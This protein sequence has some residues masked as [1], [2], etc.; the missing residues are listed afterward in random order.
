M[1]IT[2]IHTAAESALNQ[3]NTAY[4]LIAAALVLLMTPGLAFFYGGMVRTKSV[5][6]MM[7]MSF[8][9]I[10]L[11]S[12]LWLFYGFSMAFGSDPDIEKV[13]DQ[14]SVQ[15]FAPSNQT[16][17]VYYATPSGMATSQLVTLAGSGD[18][19]DVSLWDTA[20]FSEGSNDLRG[21][22]GIL[23]RGRWL[24][25]WLAQSTTSEQFGIELVRVSA[26]E[27]AAE[28]AIR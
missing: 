4:I 26:F 25:V 3:G 16:L 7:M 11:I 22:V 8:S 13:F 12:V 5:L 10:G 24:M 20:T 17:Q 18:A 27:E 1:S 15:G 28:P 19:F 9:A 14:I 2:T 23:G 21:R 6:N